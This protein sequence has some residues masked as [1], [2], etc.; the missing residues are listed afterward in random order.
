MS[1]SLLIAEPRFSFFFFLFS[2]A[3]CYLGAQ[4]CS[5]DENDVCIDCL[6]NRATRVSFG[7]LGFP[8]VRAPWCSLLVSLIVVVYVERR[9]NI[10]LGYSLLVD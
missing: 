4:Q 5:V 9:A 2:C 1:N 6:A 3:C 7:R 10:L 8:R